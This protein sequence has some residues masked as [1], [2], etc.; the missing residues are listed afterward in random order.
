MNDIVEHQGAEL[1]AP[2]MKTP[3]QMI[4]KVLETGNGIE[5]LDKLYAL[6]ER[7]EANEAKKAYVA[8]MNEFKA[9]PPSLYKD[10]TV[11]AGSATYS[12]VSLE[13]A[14]HII[15]QA[16]VKH[17][18]SHRWETQYGDDGGV[19]VSCI[20]THEL[21]HSER[22][23]LRAPA[24]NSGSK[25]SVQAIGS[26]VTYLQRYTLLAITGLAVKG[27]DDDGLATSEITDEEYQEISEL[28]EEAGSNVQKFCEHFK[29]TSVNKLLGA[30]YRKA[31]MLLKQQVAKKKAQDN[32]NS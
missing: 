22:S 30:D 24:D 15:G 20:I 28:L 14:T 4:E 12:H 10:K 19:E 5:Q 3:M 27:Q 8:A 32:E 26:T 25:N 6:Q 23:T 13:L 16:L 9:D 17:G 31:K 18:L 7:Y 21:G 11:K 1:A 29:I 2:Q